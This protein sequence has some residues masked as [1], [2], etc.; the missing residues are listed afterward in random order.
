MFSEY[1]QGKVVDWCVDR[2]KSHYGFEIDRKIAASLV[3]RLG[4]DQMRLDK[5][6]EQLSLAEK[7]D[8]SLVDT[9]V[10]LPKSESVFGLLEA[11]LTGRHSDI[12]KILAYLELNSGTEGVYMTVGLLV[13]Q[14]IALSSLVLSGGDAEAAKKMGAHPF[15]IKKL[16]PLARNLIADDLRRLVSSLSDADLQ[17]K[18][19]NVSPWLLLETVL[20]GFY[21]GSSN[22]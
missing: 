17:M 16:V 7:V 8:Q 14:L 13:S 6:L 15:V 1:E 22:R 4:H 21:E 9:L 11:T 5:F 19:T 10:P 2:A 18:T 20:I 12:K 3:E